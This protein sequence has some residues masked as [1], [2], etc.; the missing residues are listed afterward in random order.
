MTK[1]QEKI[2][3]ELISACVHFGAVQGKGM[4]VGDPLYEEWNKKCTMSITKM[5]KA[6]S[7]YATV[8]NYVEDYEPMVR[9]FRD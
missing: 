9:M 7:E 6:L 3:N 2:L 8:E 1:N 4:S 5:K